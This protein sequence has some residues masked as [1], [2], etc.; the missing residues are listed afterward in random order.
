MTNQQL[1]ID[2]IAKKTCKELNI[3]SIKIVFNSYNDNIYFDSGRIEISID[4]YL[5]LDYIKIKNN[6]HLFTV[7]KLNSINKRLKFIIIHEIIHYLQY[8]KYRK[9]FNTQV[10]IYSSTLPPEK[11]RLQ[12]IEKYADKIALHLV[13]KGI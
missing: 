4:E 11:H 10:K 5:L 1:Y 12:K 8:Y 7:I 2:S 9:W 6:K 13:N 3:P